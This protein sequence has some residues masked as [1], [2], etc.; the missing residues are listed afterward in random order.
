ML[1]NQAPEPQVKGDGH[2]LDLHSVFLTI[3]GEGPFAGRP[4]VFVRLAGCNLQCPGC[5]TEYTKGRRLVDDQMVLLEV[6]KVRAGHPATLVV[7]TGG[8]PLRQNIAP[9]CALLALSGYEVQI[10][11]NGVFPVSEDLAVLLRASPVHLVV[12]PKT[13][14]VSD[15]AAHHAMAFKYVLQAGQIDQ[16]DGLPF[17]ALMHKAAPRVARP[18]KTF[19]GP[20]YINP[21]DSQDEVL[22]EANMRATVASAMRFGHTLGLQL[23]K[24]IEMP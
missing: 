8:E 1:N 9:L 11:S 19:K 18:P 20:I 14:R 2:V 22:N 6:N 7:I 3:Q 13:S 24:I 16:Q 4:A 5:D 15:T 23:H 21:M 17:R 12:S 10:E